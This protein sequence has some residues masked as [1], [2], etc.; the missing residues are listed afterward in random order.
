[1]S[2]AV[3]VWAAEGWIGSVRKRMANGP[4]IGSAFTFFSLGPKPSFKLPASRDV[5]EA[6]AN[7][8]A[9]RSGVARPG[10]EMLT[11]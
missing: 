6:S 9:L 10:P 1:M 7:E 5:W 2:R 11:W 8:P 3:D 4:E